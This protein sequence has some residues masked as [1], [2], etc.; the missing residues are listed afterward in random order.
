MSVVFRKVT[1][2]FRSVWGSQ[3]YAAT[4][5]VIAGGVSNAVEI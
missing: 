4:I 1:G 5:S 2:C 3:F